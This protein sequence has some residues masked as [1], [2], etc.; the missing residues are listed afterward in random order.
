MFSFVP[1][2]LKK[3]LNNY[4]NTTKLIKQHSQD[5][6]G[7]TYFNRSTNFNL[8]NVTIDSI[9]GSKQPE[10]HN[11]N[12]FYKIYSPE[13]FKFRPG[14]DIY[15]D[16]KFNI[17]TP[18]QI[19]PWINLLPSLNNRELKIENQDITKDDTIQLHILNRSFTYTTDIKKNQCIGY[20]FLL[21]EKYHD[22]TTTKYTRKK[23]E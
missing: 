9:V 18:T 12:R 6:A 10:M 5:V 11:P 2:K 23:P 21:G 8:V 22:T 4:Q 19:E 7:L 15:L 13:K 20:I 14:D 3:S 17:E 1:K 16:L